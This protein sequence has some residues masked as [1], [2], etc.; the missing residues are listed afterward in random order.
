MLFHFSSSYYHIPESHR[1]QNWSLIKFLCNDLT[2]DILTMLHP[3]GNQQNQDCPWSQQYL[4]SQNKQNIKITI[5][6][7]NQC[8]FIKDF[9]YETVESDMG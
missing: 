1:R 2:K 9:N 8:F 4:I 3:W 6:Q 5:S 7:S